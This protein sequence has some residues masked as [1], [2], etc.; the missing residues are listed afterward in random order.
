M[1]L[2]LCRKMKR[3]PAV[4]DQT[5]LKTDATVPEPLPGP[6]DKEPQYPRSHLPAAGI[7]HRKRYGLIATIHFSFL[8]PKNLL[9]P[10]F[11]MAVQIIGI[12]NASPLYAF[13]YVYREI[14]ALPFYIS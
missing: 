7:R 8:I 4:N 1:Y 13:I 3:E 10:D 14:T 11:M 2:N 5:P 9:S 12:H 6:P